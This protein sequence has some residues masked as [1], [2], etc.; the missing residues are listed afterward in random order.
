VLNGHI[1]LMYQLD[2]LK[3]FLKKLYISQFT[4]YISKINVPK[5]QDFEE[6]LLKLSYLDNRF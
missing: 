2:K 4:K 6:K 1:N 3:Q 5:S